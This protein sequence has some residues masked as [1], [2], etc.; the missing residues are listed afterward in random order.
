MKRIMISALML[1]VAVWSMAVTHDE[2]GS[3]LWLRL[4]KTNTTASVTGVKG[5]AMTELQNYW[6]GGPVV[7]KRQKGMTADAYAIKSEG[8]KTVITAANDAGLLYGAFHLL[9]LRQTGQATTGLNIK[10]QPAYT[11]RILNHW[12][13]PNGTVERGFAGRSIFLNPDPQRMKM[14]ARANASIGINGPVLNNV[15]AK[16]EALTTEKP[17]ESQDDSRPVAPLR[18]PCISIHQL[19]IAHKGGRAE[20]CRPA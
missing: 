6:Q 15:N 4:E 18:H 3:R 13:N 1:L 7:L 17:A 5:T 10:E 12:D 2:D 14:Y 11:L 16:P 19:R 8:R 9:R 20:D